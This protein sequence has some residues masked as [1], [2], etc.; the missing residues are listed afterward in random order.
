MFKDIK[1]CLN[2]GTSIPIAFFIVVLLAIIIGAVAWYLGENKSIEM[3]PV[4]TNMPTSSPT[5]MPSATT[6]D[7]TSTPQGAGAEKT[8]EFP[9]SIIKDNLPL[10]PTEDEKIAACTAAFNDKGT[11]KYIEDNGVDLNDCS[12]Q[13]IEDDSIFYYHCV[14]SCK[15]SSQTIMA[16]VDW[17][18][19][20]WNRYCP[21]PVMEKENPFRFP[22]QYDNG[23]GDYPVDTPQ[24]GFYHILSIPFHNS[25]KILRAYLNSGGEE[26][27]YWENQLV[28]LVIY[29]KDL[30]MSTLIKDVEVEGGSN[31][32]ALLLPYA[33]V[34]DDSG[35]I[36]DTCKGS[37][38]AGGGSV[39]P[40]YQILSFKTKQSDWIANSSAHFYDSFG[41]VVYVAEGDKTPHYSMPGPSNDAAI[42]FKNLV[43]GGESTLL[44]EEDTNYEITSL[45]EKLG[46]LNFK[47]TKYYFSEECPREE[48]AL[49]CAEK[50]ITDRSVNLP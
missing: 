2:K 12:L 36:L 6:T 30:S 17:I 46:I 7:G 35:V 23:E 32:M 27:K 24:S 14:Y 31:W 38:G 41:K 20:Y 44:E 48:D 26:M 50:S 16:D 4:L 25:N 15:R 49:S 21:C 13:S 9:L 10:N 40:G 1:S 19:D 39:D 34:K 11:S 22:N 43:S 42:Y 8:I 47:A 5:S 29:D 18:F 28:R 33:I 3:E 37:P 45:D